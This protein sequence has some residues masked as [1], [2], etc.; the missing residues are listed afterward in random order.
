MNVL[1][2]PRQKRDQSSRGRRK[3][4]NSARQRQQRSGASTSTASRRARLLE[5]SQSDGQIRLDNAKHC[6]DH[7]SQH[8][9]HINSDRRH[10]RKHC[11]QQQ[12][13]QNRPPS[14]HA[15][16]LPQGG[17]LIL[18]GEDTVR[19]SKFPRGCERVPGAEGAS[20]KRMQ[21]IS[22]QSNAGDGCGEDVLTRLCNPKHFTGTAATG[23]LPSVVDLE[24]GVG[25]SCTG[26]FFSAAQIYCPFS[27]TPPSC[28][29]HAS[30]V[31][32]SRTSVMAI[33]VFPEVSTS[34]VV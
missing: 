26:P 16:I 3:I 31:Q 27:P 11:Q 2:T 10:P 21:A 1:A 24:G 17:G 6:H 28:T 33:S 29:F 4:D 30:R 25:V 14:T 34:A 23:H 22:E 9:H 5:Q 32:G 7:N 13:Q 18:V 8:H 19:L 15:V 12:Q 20:G